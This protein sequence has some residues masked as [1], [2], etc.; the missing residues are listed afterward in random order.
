MNLKLGFSFLF[1]AGFSLN[2]FASDQSS[3]C[4]LG[5]EVTQK[6]SLVS[7]SVRTTTNTILPNTF[8]MTFGTSGCTKHSI[9]R[10]D[11]EQLYF[12]EANL[13]QLAF[14]TAQGDGEYLRSF[15]SVMGCASVYS[16]F[17]SAMRTNYKNLISDQ[18]QPAQFLERVRSTVHLN[19]KLN[20]GCS[21]AT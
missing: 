15:A 2:A 14:D 9:V 4:G 18:L 7:S 12:V 13:E 8:S 16:D 20:L 6:N 1:I 17:S 11:K 10:N 3:G 5:W 21:V 19:S